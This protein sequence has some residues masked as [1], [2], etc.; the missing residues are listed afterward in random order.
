MFMPLECSITCHTYTLQSHH[1]L[2]RQKAIIKFASHTD[3]RIWW[4][5]HIDFYINFTRNRCCHLKLA[6]PLQEL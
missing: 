1:S 6:P 4:S 2:D 3:E 5:T